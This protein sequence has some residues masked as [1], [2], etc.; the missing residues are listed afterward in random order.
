MPDSLQ[1]P[2]TNL[3]NALGEVTPRPILSGAML[4]ESTTV[5]AAGLVDSGA[6][7]SLLPFG[8]GTALGLSWDEQRYSLS[9]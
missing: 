1:I 5:E 6:D 3:R 2:Y 8:L 4:Y 9:R 7:I